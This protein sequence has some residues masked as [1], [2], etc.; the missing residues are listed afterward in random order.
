MLPFGCRVQSRLLFP[1]REGWLG[2]VGCLDA[3][4][5]DGKESRRNEPTAHAVRT[6]ALP[7]ILIVDDNLAIHGDFAKILEAGTAS[8]LD[9]IEAELFGAGA[10]SSR[11]PSFRI[12]CAS[13]GHQALEMARQAWDSGDPYRLAFVDVRMPPGWDGVETIWHLWQLCP[14]LQAVICTAY[15]DYSWEDIIGRLGQT[16]SLMVLKKP[17]DA[18]E[19]LQVAQALTTKWALARQA[20][21]KLEELD[22]MVRER[23]RKLELEIEQ[24]VAA[25]ESLRRSMEEHLKLEEQ[26][27]Q[28]Q[29]MEAIGCLSAG[30]AHEF[31]NLLTVIQGHAGMLQ[32]RPG[33]AAFAKDSAAHI[34]RASERAA[35]LTR[36]LLAFS[37]KQPLQLRAVNLAEAASQ[38]QKMLAGLLGER[39]PLE[40]CMEPELPMI[41]ADER[42][43][44]QVLLNLVLNARDAMP[45]GGV[46]RVSAARI[47]V[48]AE[49]SRPNPAAR[50]GEFVRLR[51]EDRGCGMDRE[52]QQRAFDPFF[53]TKEVGRGTGL[54]LSTVHGIVRQHEGWIELSS[55]VGKGA[56]FDI[57]LPVW[58]PGTEPTP[59]ENAMELTQKMLNSPV[60]EKNDRR[61]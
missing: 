30:V 4:Q 34:I 14:D 27:R 17:F 55:E 1:A 35:S 44:E 36:R 24:R 31:N 18:V 25:E 22:R 46:V 12:D 53:T 38:S 59:L 49:S 7:R 47:G 6:G 16:D 26:L 37:R 58:K 32:S 50:P 15:S 11:R 33:D 29:K 5:S 56:C 45:Q 19:V 8:G 3:M 9:A 52:V 60:E 42:Q 57:Y 2:Q 39:H 23:T 61:A 13:Q 54:G 51:V 40:I 43:L 41:R 48:S 21:L 28:A 10:G 20:R